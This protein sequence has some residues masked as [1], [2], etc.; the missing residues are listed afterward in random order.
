M[1]AQ[2]R[3]AQMGMQT[4]RNGK[5]ELQQYEYKLNRAKA[6]RRDGNKCRICGSTEKLECHHIRPRSLGVDHSLHNL[7]TVCSACH[8][9]LHRV[10]SATRVWQIGRLAFAATVG[11]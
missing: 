10:R 4:K 2:G 8:H 9:D 1:V 5:K 11:A 3:Q 6:L 7:A